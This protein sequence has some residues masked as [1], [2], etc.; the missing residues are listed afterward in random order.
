M[1]RGLVWTIVLSIL[2]IVGG[3]SA[4]IVTGR[5]PPP[6]LHIDRPD[7]LVGQQG[8]LEISARG[9]RGR[10]AHLTAHVE[11]NGKTIPLLSIDE[12]AAKQL[13]KASDDSINVIKPLGKQSVP[14][15]VAGPARIVVDAD[16]TSWMRLHTFTAHVAKDV[17]VRLEPPRISVLSTHHYINHGGT[18]MVVYRATPPDVDSGVRVGDVEYPGFPA[19]GAGV[20]GADPSIKV[21]FFALLYDQPMST[22]IEAYAKDDGGNEAKVPFIEKEFDKP[23]KRSRIE[24]DDKFL[25]RVVPEI[26]EHSPELKDAPAGDLLGGFLKVNGELRQ[27]NADDITSITEDSSPTRFWSGPFVQLGNSKVEAAFA[28]DRTYVYK[29]KDVD[30]QTHLGFDL[31]VTANVPVVAA[32]AGKVLNARWLGIY[33]NCI[34]IDHGM[35]VASLYGHLSSFDVKVGD[36]VTRGQVIGKSG[37][38]GLA[39]GDHLH[40]TML[41]AGHPVNPVEWWDAHWVQDRVDRKLQELGNG[42]APP[43]AVQAK[44]AP[45]PPKTAPRERRKAPAR[46]AS[47]GRRGL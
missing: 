41:V 23:F 42:A 11:Q 36:T 13:W 6:I 47:N 30:R 19:S 40:F 28:D 1:L 46:S 3:V 5:T 35:G 26:L 22:P 9:T 18:E 45:A 27:M 7:T 43:P 33:G 31:A 17:Q 25:G 39:G 20:Q 38:T 15:L 4:Y 21:A 8:T 32:N 14:E 29:G 37:M 12:T 24:I 2:V 10:L 44:P 34:I 16:T